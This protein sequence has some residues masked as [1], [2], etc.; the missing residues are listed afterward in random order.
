MSRL[1]QSL[2]LEIMVWFGR[3]LIFETLKELKIKK[4]LSLDR[5]LL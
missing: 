3:D 5:F 4:K 1:D 2:R